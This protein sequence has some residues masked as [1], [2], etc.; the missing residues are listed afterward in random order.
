MRPAHI[1]GR[2]DVG[3]GHDKVHAAGAAFGATAAARRAG[4]QDG[5]LA[6]VRWPEQALVGPR[7]RKGEP[8]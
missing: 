2:L 8:R 6:G 1:R 3:N 7:I 5:S 4:V